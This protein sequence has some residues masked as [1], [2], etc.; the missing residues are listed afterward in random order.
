MPAWELDK[1]ALKVLE[2]AARHEVTQHLGGSER[3]PSA[4]DIAY[5]RSVGY[6]TED[7]TIAHDDLVERLNALAARTQPADVAESFVAGIGQKRPDYRSPIASYVLARSLPRHALKLQPKAHCPCLVCE[8]WVKG[9]QQLA[10]IY[11]NSSLHSRLTI[12][13]SLLPTYALLDLEWFLAAPR[14]RASDSDWQAFAELLAALRQAPGKFAANALSKLIGK[15][16]GSN[17]LQRQ[18]TLEVLSAI[19]LLEPKSCASFWRAF[20]PY[21]DRARIENINDWEFP[22]RLWRG[23]DG[24]NEDAVSYWFRKR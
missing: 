18:R 11:R 7:E 10:T 5:A 24:V 21:E 9:D 13:G 23:S 20:T 12:G 3:P 14:V 15:R 6:W 2:Q 16:I 19:G 8:T 4:E 1:R 17:D 22:M